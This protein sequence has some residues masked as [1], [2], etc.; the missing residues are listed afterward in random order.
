MFPA[1]KLPSFGRG[2]DILSKSPSCSQLNGILRFYLAEFPSQVNRFV[3]K[4]WKTTWSSSELPSRC[5]LTAENPF[6]FC[7]GADRCISG[8]TKNNLKL[9]HSH[10]KMSVKQGY[11][12]SQGPFCCQMPAILKIFE[13][14]RERSTRISLNMNDFVL[15]GYCKGVHGAEK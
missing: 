8:L 15:L 14:F 5:R 2:M 3:L 11:L 1:S 9:R 6:S 12:L 10:K 4:S 7:I 13:V